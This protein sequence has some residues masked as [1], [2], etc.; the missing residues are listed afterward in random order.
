[1]RWKTPLITLT[2]LGLLAF[3]YFAFKTG[4]TLLVLTNS[5]ND[6][7]RVE[8]IAA[9]SQQGKKDLGPGHRTGVFVFTAQ[10]RDGEID[11]SCTNLAT[12]TSRSLTAGYI[13]TGMPDIH[14]IK[15]DSCNSISSY[16]RLLF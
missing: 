5:G 10:G 16:W 13:S 2:V 14:V 12:H 6:D 1:M 11:I 15:I 9:D 7:V 3:L 8:I 4:L